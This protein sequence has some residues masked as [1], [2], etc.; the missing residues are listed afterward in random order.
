MNTRTNTLT[1]PQID[2][3]ARLREMTA[4]KIDFFRTVGRGYDVSRGISYPLIRGGDFGYT[5]SR[6]V[7]AT[8]DGVTFEIIWD[9]L[10]NSLAMYNRGAAEFLDSLCFRTTQIGLREV[11][12]G[13][14]RFERGTE[15]GRPDRQRQ[16]AFRS[17]GLPLEKFA[18][19]T[20]WTRDALLDMTQ[21]EID[22]QHTSVLIADNSNIMNEILRAAFNDDSY[23]FEDQRAGAVT[24]MPLYNGDSEVPP[25]FEGRVFT[26][27]HTHYSATGAMPSPYSANNSNTVFN[28]SAAKVMLNA[29]REHGHYGNITMFIATDLEDDV[30]ALTDTNGD[31]TFFENWAYNNPNIQIA[32]ASTRDTAVVGPEFIGV[33][34]GMKVR[35]MTWMPL[36]YAFAWNS[37]GGNSRLS[38]FA[39]RE[40]ENPFQ[41]GLQLINPDGN[42]TYPV[43]DSFYERWFGIGVINRANGVVMYRGAAYAEPTI[44]SAE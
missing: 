24:V 25:M 10:V 22:A 19:A 32:P 3:L 29:L 20:G 13:S 14:I 1:A 34:N 27:P 21:A 36:G 43:I 31:P 44:T 23:T 5:D 30:R 17:R 9:D 16:G 2:L 18:V 39:Y 11:T 37:Y 33:T 8:L 15:Y 4:G 38:P 41:R 6:D 40:K 35:V 12:P 42:D 28:D 7:L 26:A